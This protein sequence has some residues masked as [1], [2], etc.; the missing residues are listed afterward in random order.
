MEALGES[1]AS[2]VQLGGCRATRPRRQCRCPGPWGCLGSRCGLQPPRTSSSLVPPADT[3]PG[4]GAVR[5][6]SV[7]AVRAPQCCSLSYALTEGPLQNGASLWQ[8]CPSQW[9]SGA[10]PPRTHFP[11]QQQCSSVTTISIAV[12]SHTKS[13][14]Q[15]QGDCFDWISVH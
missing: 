14:S 15:P 13:L 2:P 6:L 8:P 4:T 10:C 7:Q 3:F 12:L 1:A 5:A 11:L 9:H